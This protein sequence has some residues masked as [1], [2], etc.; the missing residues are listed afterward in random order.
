MSQNRKLVVLLHHV[1]PAVVLGAPNGY[2]DVLA[3]ENGLAGLWVKLEDGTL[4][5]AVFEK[6]T[7]IVLERKPAV[8]VLQHK[9]RLEVGLF[10]ARKV[11][12]LGKNTRT[13]I[14]VS[15]HTSSV[16]DDLMAILTSENVGTFVTGKDEPLIYIE[17]TED[18]LA[19][20]AIKF[21]ELLEAPDKA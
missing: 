1:L 15:R 11:F 6:I 13:L 21:W 16:L 2:V 19:E 3:P 10:T 17:Y 18:Q 7:S 20:A 12:E 4:D 14:R 9:N 8:I 5:Y